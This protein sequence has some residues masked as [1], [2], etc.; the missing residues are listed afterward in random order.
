[1]K[2]WILD[3]NPRLERQQCINGALVEL[4]NATWLE[5]D[6]CVVFQR[7]SNGKFY[8]PKDLPLMMDPGIKIME[9]FR[10]VNMGMISSSRRFVELIESGEYTWNMHR[11]DKVLPKRRRRR[12]DS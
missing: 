11:G 3:F 10:V 1:M 5:K 4:K 2:S 6:P 7:W 9:A 8:D 12:R